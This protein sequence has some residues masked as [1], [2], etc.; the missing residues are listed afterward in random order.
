MVLQLR[1]YFRSHPGPAWE[2]SKATPVR[3]HGGNSL[4]IHRDTCPMIP[5]NCRS[6]SPGS[7]FHPQWNTRNRT[8][9]RKE[10]LKGRV[11]GNRR[12]RIAMASQQTQLPLSED[13]T[14]DQHALRAFSDSGIP[15]G[16]ADYTTLVIIHGLGWHARTYLT[17][18][19]AVDNPTRHRYQRSSTSSSRTQ[20]SS[21][22]ASSS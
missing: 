5:S 12:H 10:G 2:G 15:N 19:W 17:P 14:T 11:W 6:C 4:P 18:S 20:H 3:V 9:S 7:R 8:G 13:N 1:F 16:R 22:P 21:T